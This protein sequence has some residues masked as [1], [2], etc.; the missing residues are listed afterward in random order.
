MGEDAKKIESS[1]CQLFGVDIESIY[2][3]DMRRVVSNAR[4]YLWF[5]LHLHFGMSY[6][7]IARQYKR[8][9]RKVIQY[10]M[11]ILF[12]VNN[13]KADKETYEKIITLING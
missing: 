7:D 8:S 6:L 10:C 11:E 1:I 13:H 4:H 2:S 9:R 5:I 3:R 12:R